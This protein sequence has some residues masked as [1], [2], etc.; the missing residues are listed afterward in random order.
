MIFQKYSS[1][2]NRTVL[3]NVL[4]GL[5]LNRESLGYSPAEMKARAMDMINKVGLI[6][7][8]NKY[9]YQLSGGQQ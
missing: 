2:P 3:Q 4:F 6:G 8:E 5:E 9:P 1:F 7:H